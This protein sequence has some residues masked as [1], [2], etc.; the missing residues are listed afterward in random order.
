[1][2]FLEMIIFF[3]CFGLHHTTLLLIIFLEE[4]A[5]FSIIILASTICHNTYCISSFCSSYFLT[6]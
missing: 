4:H 1:M 2:L 6:G 3:S 5:P